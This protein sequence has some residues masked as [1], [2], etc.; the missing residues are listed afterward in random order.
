[1]QILRFKSDDDKMYTGCDFNGD[2]ACIIEGNILS[3]FEV[4]RTRRKIVQFLPPIVPSAIFCIGLNYRFHAK[5]TGLEIPKYP[6]LFMKNVSAALGHKCD[7]QIPSVCKKG[8][9]VDYEAELAV[10]IK[11]KIK[12]VSIKKAYES[13]LG[14]TCANDISARK[15]QMHAGGGQWI[16][17]KSFDTFCPFGPVIV[18]PDE[19]KDPDNLDIKCILNGKTMQSSNT[20]DMI[21][22]VGQII[23][24]LSQS[25][26]LMP[27]TV[28][29]TGTPSG[30]GF[31]RKPP[32]YLQ[33]GDKLQT[34]IENI[35]VLENRVVQEEI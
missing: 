22:S 14:Y 18:M 4:T 19:I 8:A 25:T 12:N 7:I 5:E 31:T 32:V 17:G 33:P 23:S 3:E 21:F 16:R 9:E 29:L 24:Y 15:W 2:S 35:G 34:K 1:M 13:V 27:G 6:V 20:M 28:I 30:V 11:N 10:V 26:T